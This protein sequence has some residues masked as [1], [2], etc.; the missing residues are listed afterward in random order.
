MNVLRM[1][2]W[3]TVSLTQDLG[4]LCWTILGHQKDTLNWIFDWNGVVLMQN[5]SL[6]V[7]TFSHRPFYATISVQMDMAQ[8]A[9]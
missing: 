6:F 7:V 8:L 3:N 9:A 5:L 4:S 2:K 1:R